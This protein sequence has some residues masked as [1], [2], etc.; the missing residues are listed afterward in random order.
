[1]S[2]SSRSPIEWFLL[3]IIIANV[4]FFLLTLS[5]VV[6]LRLKT[7]RPRIIAS[8]KVSV[9]IPV[10]DEEKNIDRCLDT[11]VA[12]NYR[13]YEIIVLD[14][15]SS[16]GTWE[17]IQD[18][19]RRYPHVRALKGKE[20]PE[21]WFGKPHAMHQLAQIASGT[22]YMFTD[23]DTIHKP[24]VVSWA[25]TNILHHKADVLSGYLRP[26]MKTL[27]E[28]AVV[29]NIFL[30]MAL[31]L[32]FWLISTTR[33]PLF[34]FAIGQ[35]MIFKA[36]TY[37]SIGGYSTVRKKI[38]EDVYIAREAKRQGFKVVFIDAKEQ[39]EVRMYT[40]FSEALNGIS[41]NIYDFFEKKLYSLLILMVFLSII[42]LFPVVCLFYQVSTSGPFIDLSVLC[43]SVFFVTWAIVMLDRRA[44]GWLSFLYP[45]L[46]LILLFIGVKS[47]IASIWGGGYVWKGRMVR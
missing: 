17:I 21:D 39:S 30:N 31:L 46:F 12:Q 1:M 14:D 4:Y 33:I 25:V 42:L 16:D 3:V 8:P 19:E 35:L 26:I 11:L 37:H 5:N 38:T 28:K 20:L 13:N 41:K 6:F 24:T 9:L 18:Y 32:P 23:A 27:G 43:V 47:F 44:I 10:R 22:F 7:R 29:P 36:D 34:S 45:F 40:G 15:C 2:F